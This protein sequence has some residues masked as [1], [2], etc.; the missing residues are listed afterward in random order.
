MIN[1]LTNKGKLDTLQK[2]IV[3]VLANHLRGKLKQSEKNSVE[4]LKKC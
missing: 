4:S 1:A 2:E 3:N